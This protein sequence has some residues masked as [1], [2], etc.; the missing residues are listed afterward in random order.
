MQYHKDCPITSIEWC[1]QLQ[2]VFACSSEDDQ[3]TLWD[4]SMEQDDSEM[5][6]A[7]QQADEEYPVHLLFNHMGQKEIKEL[8]WHPQIPGLILSTALDGLNVFKTINV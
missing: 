4:I 5:A 3:L 2:Y 8:H 1:P 7:G 6:Q